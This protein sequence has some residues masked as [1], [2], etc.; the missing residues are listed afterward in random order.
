MICRNFRPRSQSFELNQ[1]DSQVDS[2]QLHIGDSVYSRKPL[3]T[4]VAEPFFPMLDLGV[5]KKDS[6]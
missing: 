3:L 4:V 2:Y 6:A 1:L 5:L